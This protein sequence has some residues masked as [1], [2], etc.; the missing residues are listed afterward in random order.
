MTHL[1]TA[2]TVVA[3]AEAAFKAASEVGIE[4]FREILTTFEAATHYPTALNFI[5]HVS[6]FTEKSGKPTN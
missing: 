1:L 5:N 3:N 4:R 2:L 6:P